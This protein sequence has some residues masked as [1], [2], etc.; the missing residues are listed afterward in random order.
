MHHVVSDGWSLG[1]FWR[2][3]GALYEA[4]SRGEPSPLAELPVQYADYALWQR[5][6]LT[7]EVLEEQLG[8]WREQL[9]GAGAL[10]LPT[11]HPRPAVRTHLGARQELVLPEPLTRALKELSRQEGTTLFMVLLGA[12][13][14]L[15]SRYSG[16]EDVAVGSPIAGRNQAETEDLIGFFVNTLVMRTDLSGDPTFKELLGRVRE[17]A[18]GAYAHQDLPFER[19]V[20]E[21][22]AR[23]RPEPHAALPSLLQHAEH[24]RY[25]NRAKRTGGRAHCPIRRRGDV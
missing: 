17:V 19:L 24:R 15:L 9:A 11:D 4:F 14:A 22:Q 5:R 12:F 3:L 1:V 10:E 2:E 25:P 21:L 6:W 23:A 18:L 20:E 13:Q 8:Y 7:G 16:Q